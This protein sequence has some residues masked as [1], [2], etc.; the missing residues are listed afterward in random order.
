[1]RLFTA[2]KLDDDMREQ[3][4]SAQDKLRSIGLRGR[5]NKEDSFHLTLAF[6]GEYD[7]PQAV[8]DALAR[9][10]FEPFMLRLSGEVGQFDGFVV[11]AGLEMT[12]ELRA[13]GE[14]VRQELSAAGIP[15]DQKA[16][17]PH[18][19][20]LRLARGEEIPPLDC[21]EY[22]ERRE[23]RP[24]V[25]EICA[26]LVRK[27]FDEEIGNEFYMQLRSP[28]DYFSDEMTDEVIALGGIIK[29][30]F[31]SVV[32]R[33]EYKAWIKVR[34]LKVIM[35]DELYRAFDEFEKG[36]LVWQREETYQYTEK[37]KH[38]LIWSGQG[39]LG[40]VCDIFTDSGGR[41][42]LVRAACHRQRLQQT[43]IAADGIL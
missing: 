32:S 36:P 16:F 40:E 10:R 3:L 18:I 30:R 6:I 11:W 15:F 19:T 13:L 43:G 21:E 34:V 39:D 25:G 8:T 27:P 42:H 35:N 22:W 38:I 41:E 1:M 4:I 23:K 31:E 29:C 33:D 9:V 20:L 14:A 24:E 2:I 26:V 12:D 5:Y 28:R 7:D 17:N 37:W